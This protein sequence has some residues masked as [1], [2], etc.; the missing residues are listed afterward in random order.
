MNAQEMKEKYTMLYDYMAG[1]KKTA[2][3]MSFGHV[4]NEM[5]DWMIANK[6]DVAEEMIEKL[7][8]IKWNNYLTKKEAEA[9]VAKMNPKAPW[10]RDTWKQAMESFGIVMEEEPYYNSCAMWVEMNKVYS[11][12]AATIAKMLGKTVQEVPAE[13]MVK[14]VHSLALD[15]LKDIDGVYDI[16]AYF[17][18]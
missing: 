6:P 18:V 12:H 16:R 1:S 14:A 11:D 10:P 13:T 15:N 7:C 4:M 17:S 2:H 5:M 8:A 9:I 3:M